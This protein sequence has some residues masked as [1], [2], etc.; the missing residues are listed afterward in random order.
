MML[1]VPRAF[2]SLVVIS[3][4]LGLP[5]AAEGED[6]LV[7]ETRARAAKPVPGR[8]VDSPRIR[9]ID[10]APAMSDPTALPAAAGLCTGSE[11]VYRDDDGTAEVGLRTDGTHGAWLNAYTIEG[12]GTTIEAI[13]AGFSVVPSGFPATVY[14]WSDP[15]QDGDPTDA[16]VLASAPT[17]TV[18]LD[19]VRVDIPDTYV[20]E[21]GTIFFV[22]VVM[23]YPEP[24]DSVFP[25]ALDNT[26]TGTAGVNWIVGAEGP[27]DPNDLT[28]GA[29][30][31][32]IVEQILGVE[33]WN[34]VMRAVTTAS[35]DCN[36]NGL[37]DQDDINSGASLDCNGNC[38]PDECEILIADC[39]NNG[40]PDDCDL[41]GPP[42]PLYVVDDGSSENEVGLIEGG[43]IAWLNRFTASNNG[44][45]ISAVAVSYGVVPEGTM[46]EI[47][48]W[49]DPNNDGNPADGQVIGFE[50]SV[51]ASPNSDEFIV[52]DIF[53]TF[54]G[55]AGTNFFA[56]VLIRNTAAG[57][58][59]AAIDQTSDEG[60]SWLAAGSGGVDVTNLGGSGLFGQPAQFGLAGNFLVRAIVDGELPPNDCNGNVIP[61]ECDIASGT[62]ADCNMNGVPD[63]CELDG[64]DCDGNGVP[65]ECDVDCNMN[66]VPDACEEPE[67][68]CDGNGI[69]DSC[70][71]T[72]TG[73]VGRYFDNFDWLGSP[74]VSRIDATVN[75][76]L[77]F[78][79]PAPLPNDQFSIRWTGAIV[80]NVTGDH[81]LIFEHDDELRFYLNGTRLIDAGTGTSQVTVTLTAGVP[82]HVRIDYR[83]NFFQQRCVFRWIA[84]G[85]AEEVVPTSVLRLQGDL[86]GNDV[87]D[88]CEFGDCN[89]NFVPDN[90]EI[91]AGANDCDQDGILDACEGACD[92]DG[93]GLLESCE[94]GLS[95]LVGQYFSAAD[96]PGTIG[97]RL[98]VRVDPEINFNWSGGSPDPRVPND[99]FTVRW[100]G[101]VTT[102]SSAGTYTFYTKSDDGARLWV[103]GQLLID[104]Y[105]NQGSTEHSGTITL[106]ANTTYVIRMDYFEAGGGA[107]ASLSWEPPGEAKAIIPSS[108]LSALADGDGDG[109]PDS[110]T[111][112]CNGNGIPDAIDVATGISEDC[113]G[114]CTPDEC[115]LLIVPE[116]GLAHW[117]FEGA[118]ATLVDSGP[119][120][121]DG[122][123][124]APAFRAADVP[125][126]PVPQTGLANAQ[127]IDF[128]WLSPSSSGYGEVPDVDNALTMGDVDFTIEAWVKLDHLSDTSSADERQ[129]LLMKKPLPTKDARIDYAVLVQR[130][131]SVPATNYGAGTGSGREL[132]VIFGVGGDSS[133]TWGVTSSLE[134]ND[135]DW[136][137]VSIAVYAGDNRVRFGIDG[138]F[139]FVTY[140][141]SE[142]RTTN[143]GPLRIGAHQNGV[144]LNNHF[145]RGSIDEVRIS[146][147]IVPVE[148]LLDS[149]GSPFSEDADGNGIPD[150]CVANPCPADFDGSDDVGF[151]DLLSVLTNWGPCS[152]CPQDLDGSGDVGFDDLLAVLTAW[153]A[154]P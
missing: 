30:E 38:I 95:G 44:E 63:D 118:G 79:P 73:L 14:L 94:A 138:T 98:L 136:H 83:E 5:Q 88:I 4:S 43:D 61:D 12:D 102:T 127:S 10:A 60:Q 2:A 146:R 11:F 120:G 81:T 35:F 97:E 34:M 64:N 147:A 119:N 125:V 123:L 49:D 69:E 23:A 20:G 132:Q 76:P 110:C 137:F 32:G 142:P 101:A 26:P 144:G 51:V 129:Y 56:G 153:G 93:N 135:F 151:N 121:L 92:C 128:G 52:V 25:C 40:V 42:I 86:N 21:A 126:D 134:I 22:G 77:D 66:G 67:F 150:E 70:Q 68:D 33:P 117:R 28:N 57:D 113:N 46:V 39:N 45:V 105:V 139:E 80:P 75:F 141:S 149:P 48:V 58:F 72:E 104:E 54:V 87:A 71:V 112:D 91:A 8:L 47:Y 19:V 16:I 103:N 7:G 53:D 37:P 24:V 18:E 100:T 143:N 124:I 17:T 78:V 3:A 145:L 59:P 148:R 111:D 130:G 116:F 15:N 89:G 50:T 41:G 6:R 122:A 115:D 1:Y 74:A 82:H 131:N 27:I 36:G 9:T 108:A 114:N 154:C 85:S 13:D 140:S 65:D 106:A 96:D 84:P 109:V 107:D 62:S 133:T 29:V 31:F 152:G 55:T 90:F 99:E